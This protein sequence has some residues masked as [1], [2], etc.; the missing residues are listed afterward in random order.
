[1][2]DE[3]FRRTMLSSLKSYKR[4]ME[5]EYCGWK[6]HVKA[7]CW[8]LHGKPGEHNS[9]S[10]HELDDVKDRKQINIEIL[11]NMAL[12]KGLVPVLMTHD[13]YEL[14][15]IVKGTSTDAK[16]IVKVS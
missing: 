13:E 16:K 14:W 15:K 12:E 5:C 1:M 8:D 4:V 10:R 11:F 6:G 2:F 3:L 9:E 7:F